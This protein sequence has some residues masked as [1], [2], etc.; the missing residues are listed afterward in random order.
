MHGSYP[1]E[2][3]VAYTGREGMS[4]AE[5]VALFR[6]AKVVMGMHGAGLSH[7]IF[8]AP[9]TAIIELLFM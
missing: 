8:S 1:G 9:G 6:R 2:K 7:S 5:T 4:A 3:I